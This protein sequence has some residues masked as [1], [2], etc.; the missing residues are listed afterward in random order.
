LVLAVGVGGC[1][2]D[3]GGGD[4]PPPTGVRK[5]AMHSVSP[6][7]VEFSE[8]GYAR[9]V[10]AEVPQ[11]GA[12]EEAAVAFLAAYPELFGLQFEGYAAT[13]GAVQAHDDGAFIVLFETAYRGIPIEGGDIVVVVRDGHVHLVNSGLSRVQAELETVPSVDEASASASV[14]MREPAG[15]EVSGGTLVFVDGGSMASGDGGGLALGW[16]FDVRGGRSS[17]VVVSADDGALLWQAPAGRTALTRRLVDA[18]GEDS[19]TTAVAQGM[20]LGTE[21]GLEV[22]GDAEAEVMYGAAQTAYDYYA[23]LAG[24][25]NFDNSCNGPPSDVSTL[26]LVVRLGEGELGPNAQWRLDDEAIAFSSGMVVEDIFVHEY[27]HAVLDYAP[28]NGLGY[29]LEAGALNES[30]AD[31]FA[32]FVTSGTGRWTMGEGVSALDPSTGQPIGAV[33]DLSNPAAFGQPD[34]LEGFTAVDGGPC[35]EGVCAERFVCRNARCVCVKDELDAQGNVITNCDNGNVHDNSGI[36]N[37]AVYL[38]I[39]GGDHAS[40]SSPAVR[41]VDIEKVEQILFRAVRLM[42]HNETFAMWRAHVMHVCR[43]MAKD[44]SPAGFG[45]TYEDCGSIINAFAAVGLGARDSD[46]DSWDD[47]EDRCKFSY[48]PTGQMDTEEC[49]T[50]PNALCRA[51]RYEQAFVAFLGG[52]DI[53]TSRSA[54]DAMLVLSR[55]A[56]VNRDFGTSYDVAVAASALGGTG[57]RADALYIGE[58]VAELRGDTEVAESLG[59]EGL[60]ASRDSGMCEGLSGED[61]DGCAA[62]QRSWTRSGLRQLLLDNP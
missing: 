5:L 9:M 62:M 30:L 48:D 29:E 28:P 10:R 56:L 42:A 20:V 51:L 50:D 54:R 43:G 37:H 38:M 16:A 32:A 13:P 44:S 4:L 57:G 17:R 45:V 23:D 35:D 31:V 27:T 41:P 49:D 18:A 19:T 1:R 40:R 22:S 34:H 15:A 61:L 55:C 53:G 36:L 12:P 52:L 47:D 3:E 21:A 33:R 24:W 58:F 25:E 2:S 11:E 8:Y 39:E 60:L 14:S 46:R 6:I 7:D 26:N 59:A